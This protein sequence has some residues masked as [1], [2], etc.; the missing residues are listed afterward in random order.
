VEYGKDMDRLPL[1]KGKRH[2]KQIITPKV[3][4]YEG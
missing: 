2:V 3:D 4:S 1:E